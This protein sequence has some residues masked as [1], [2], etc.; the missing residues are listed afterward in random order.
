[1]RRDRV[2]TLRVCFQISDFRFLRENERKI[3][4]IVEI[5]CQ[6]EGCGSI[7]AN[8]G[9]LG[10]CEEIGLRGDRY[11]VKVCRCGCS[12]VICFKKWHFECRDKRE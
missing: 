6:E 9:L 1:M 2:L 3:L 8:G 11:R 7:R 4:R 12:F 10:W 5:G